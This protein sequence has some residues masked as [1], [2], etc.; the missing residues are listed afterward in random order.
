M[1]ELRIT[2]LGPGLKLIKFLLRCEYAFAARRVHGDVATYVNFAVQGQNNRREV[3]ITK[4]PIRFYYTMAIGL[5]FY[6]ALA[7]TS[8]AT[9]RNILTK[10]LNRI[11]IAVQ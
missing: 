1:R 10:I 7:V 9:I 3:A 2:V 5:S 6:C 11:G 8:P 4:I